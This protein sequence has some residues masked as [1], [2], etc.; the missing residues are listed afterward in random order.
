MHSGN[1]LPRGPK[2]RGNGNNGNS[3]A[4]SS[5]VS[6]PSNTG[7]SQA[8][9]SVS[10]HPGQATTT[11]MTRTKQSTTTQDK[12]ALATG[13]CFAAGEKAAEGVKKLKDLA[14]DEDFRGFDESTGGFDDAAEIRNVTGALEMSQKL[15]SL[16]LNHETDFGPG[17]KAEMSDA[18]SEF[19]GCLTGP[20][21]NQWSDSNKMQLDRY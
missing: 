16:E 14:D 6:P 13:S 8:P 7:T 12:T 3:R 19:I 20:E 10:S 17:R 2:G 15:N 11:P 4:Q 21:Q 1:S 18:L 5:S 9:A